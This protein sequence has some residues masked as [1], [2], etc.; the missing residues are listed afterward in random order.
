M[1][2]F[3]LRTSQFAIKLKSTLFEAFASPLLAFWQNW[4]TKIHTVIPHQLEELSA[5]ANLVKNL[6]VG[7][8]Y[9]IQSTNFHHPIAWD[10]SP[11]SL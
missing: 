10:Y 5:G 8:V 6:C 9:C 2:V 11:R 4:L 7:R 3:E 1:V